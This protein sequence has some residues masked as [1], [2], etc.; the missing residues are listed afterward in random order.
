MRVSREQIE[1]A[2]TERG[3]WTRA[4]LAEWGVPWPPPKGWKKRLGTAKHFQPG[5]KYSDYLKTELW[6][7]IREQVLKRDGRKCRSCGARASQVHHGSYDPE[8][9]AGARLDKLYAICGR[10]HA[11]VSLDIFGFKRPM[12]EQHEWS[13]ALTL[14][15]KPKRKHPLKLALKKRRRLRSIEAIRAESRAYAFGERK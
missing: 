14:V 6:R 11:A 2:R 7:K 8:T 9:L 1:K 15:P 13:K 5:M 4:Q 3:G 12:S 10:C